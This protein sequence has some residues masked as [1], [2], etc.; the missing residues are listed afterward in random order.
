MSKII[1]PE[2]ANAV[3]NVLCLAGANESE[4]ETWLAYAIGRKDVPEYRFRGVFGL[5]GKVRQQ[6][7]G[8]WH[9]LYYPEDKTPEREAVRHLANHLL[10][11]VEVPQEHL[12]CLDEQGAI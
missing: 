11:A 1:T 8:Y 5:G 7:G 10:A 3:W 2:I 12:E 6:N 9:V 4:R